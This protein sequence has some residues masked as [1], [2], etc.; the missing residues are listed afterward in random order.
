MGILAV[1]LLQA[2]QTISVPKPRQTNHI[3]VEPIALQYHRATGELEDVSADALFARGAEKLAKKEFAEALFQYRMLLK[4]FGASKF[5]LPALYNAAL[6]Y[7][8][9]GQFD[10]AAQRYQDVIAKADQ[11]RDIIDATFRLGGCYAELQKWELSAAI[12]QKLLQREDLTQ[13]EKIEAQARQAL[14]LFRAEKFEQTR[15]VLA[16]AIREGEKLKAQSDQDG[17]LLEGDFYYAMV[18]YY[19]AALSHQFFRK[20]QVEAKAK[21]GEQLDEKARLLLLA[22][23]GYIDAIKVKNHY[24]AVAAGFQIGALYREFYQVMMTVLPDFAESAQKNANA[25]KISA[26]DAHKQLVEVYQEEVHKKI[27]PLLQKAVRVFEKNV[28]VAERLGVQNAWVDK[29]RWQL[30]E[31]K[32]LLQA[33]P[34]EAVKFLLPQGQMPEDQ[35]GLATGK[36]DNRTGNDSEPTEISPRKQRNK[37][38]EP[39]TGATF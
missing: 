1:A 8:G 26:Q 24:W 20:T 2:C 15:N 37:Q 33:S 34:E 11:S 31:L 30:E 32:L 7:E 19:W 36:S 16:Q 3:E 14:A 25:A 23:A 27:I 22:Q 39:P 21:M 5:A 10:L 28:L 35:P 9:L 29:S 4:N 6:A 38:L 18:H 12:Y 13:A 17:A